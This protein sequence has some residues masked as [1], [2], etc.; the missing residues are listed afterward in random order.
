[1]RVCVGPRRHSC[2]VT[3]TDLLVPLVLL[4]AG[5]AVGYLVGRTL[6]RGTSAA[7]LGAAQSAAEAA[8]SRAEVVTRERDEARADVERARTELSDLGRQLA[9]VSSTLDHER[10]SAHQR[11]ADLAA[12]QEQ[13]REQF[14]ALA[15]KALHANS[16]AVI[17]L[18][19]QQLAK[20]QQ[21]Q[22]SELEKR[23][24]QVENLVAPLKESLTKVDDHVREL[25]SKRA[26]AY[27]GLV[28]QVKSMAEVQS[29]LSSETAALVTALRR[30]QTRGQW[31]ET[32]LRRAVEMAG[33]VEHCDFSEQLT[34]SSGSG[35]QRPD[36]VIN[37]PESRRIVVDAKVSLAAYL[38]ALESDDPAYQAERM[39]SHAKSLKEHVIGLAG[40][41]Y[42]NQ[43]DQ[44]PDFVVL[45]VPGESMLAPAL[46]QDPG[47]LDYAFGKRVIIA[48]PT[49]LIMMLRT[50]AYM[51]QQASVTENAIEVSNLGRELYKR[52]GTLGEHLD[53]L[54][55]SI[56]STVTNYN[57]TIGSLERQVLVSARRM[58]D[59]GLGQDE[60]PEQSAIDEAVRPVTAAELMAW[61]E[62]SHRSAVRAL[63]T[64]DAQAG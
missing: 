50:A 24:T 54:G 38:D 64:S 62:E 60:L 5:L 12:A 22:R 43:F 1:M 41:A 55:R 40:K 14:E 51:L 6:A 59:F 2:P 25:E 58:N 46:E 56:T 57:K 7:N 4:L 37:L 20:A 13:L 27:S 61:E 29:K 32:Q 45:F 47:L 30:P 26:D 17:Q 3:A 10:T 21:Q 39:K 52:L 8:T 48:T 34:A 63:P 31:G 9:V 49:I 53:K 44:S 36:M 19:E 11:A 15:S 35:G 16:E 33:M 23:S 42:W 28:E 18:A